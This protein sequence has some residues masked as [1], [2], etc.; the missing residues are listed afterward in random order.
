[1]KLAGFFAKRVAVIE[2]VILAL[3]GLICWWLGRRTLAGCNNGLFWAGG[4]AIVFGAFSLFGGSQ[5]EPTGGTRY[6]LGFLITRNPSDGEGKQIMPN[7]EDSQLSAIFM[8]LAGITTI[9]TG[10]ILGIFNA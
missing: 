9:V 2:I 7:L 1:M 6:N 8:G 3:T 5:T 4:A 10:L